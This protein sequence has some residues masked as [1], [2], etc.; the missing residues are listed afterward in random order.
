MPSFWL[1][2]L[3]VTVAVLSQESSWISSVRFYASHFCCLHLV[4]ILRFNIKSSLHANFTP[5]PLSA[6][7]LTSTQL[8]CYNFSLLENSFLCSFMVIC[9]SCNAF[10]RE[11]LWNDITT[12]H[13][14]EIS[15]RRL[16]SQCI[17][18]TVSYWLIAVAIKGKIDISCHCH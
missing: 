8:S 9:K 3:R 12:F 2:M 14:S 17:H 4:N 18:L 1:T 5:H 13:F 15:W 7:K 16:L 11:R 6:C 10:H